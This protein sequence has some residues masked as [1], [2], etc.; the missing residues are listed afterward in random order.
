MVEPRFVYP[1]IGIWVVFTFWLFV[2]DT[3][4]KKSVQVFV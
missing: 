3:A 1:F 4:V 2:N